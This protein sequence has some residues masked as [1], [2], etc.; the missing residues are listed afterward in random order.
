MTSRFALSKWLA[1]ATTTNN[2][3]ADCQYASDCFEATTTV[4]ESLQSLLVYIEHLLVCEFVATV[5][6]QM[7][8]TTLLNKLSFIS[9][10][11]W[12]NLGTPFGILV[13]LTSC[14]RVMR[15]LNQ[16]VEFVSA[17]RVY[18]GPTTRRS[19]ARQRRQGYSI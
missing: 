1:G 7:F 12:V 6:G 3:A 13:V 19:Q 15:T 11:V 8:Q 2:Q 4:S 16:G 17:G 14:L 5:T 18:I 10:K 9:W